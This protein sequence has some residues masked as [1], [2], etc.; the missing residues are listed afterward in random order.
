MSTLAILLEEIPLRTE[1]EI[2]PSDSYMALT[3][4][5]K[6]WIKELIETDNSKGNRSLRWLKDWGLLTLT[7]GYLITVLFVG[8]RFYTHTNDRLDVIEGKLRDMQAPLAP[9]KVMDELSLLTPRSLSRNL[10]ALRKVA[11]QPTA[12]VTPTS[13]QISVISKNLLKVNSSVPDYWPTLLQFVE[14]ASNASSS[15]APAPGSDHVSKVSD[16]H[17]QGIGGIRF[18]DK[19]TYELSGV[20]EGVA[21]RDDR[22]ILTPGTVLRNVRFVNCAFEFAGGVDD[23]PKGLRDAGQMLLAS[24]LEN[25]YVAGM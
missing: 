4:A 25:A 7:V 14:F 16:I 17:S 6:T 24:G 19:T 18:A 13:L 8:V 22:I 1:N 3:A 20:I 10:P 5:D 9:K 2:L 21:F 15:Q 23:A 12:K 11:E